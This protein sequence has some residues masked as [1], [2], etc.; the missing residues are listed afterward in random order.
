LFTWFSAGGKNKIKGKAIEVY[1]LTKRFAGHRALSGIDF[2]VQRGSIHGFL[3]PNG[4]GKTTAIK[5]ILGLIPATSGRVRVLGEPLRFGRKLNFLQHLNYLPQDPVF[6]EGLT[7][8]EALN[9]V[10]DIY[11]LDRKKSRSRIDRLLNYFQLSDA[12]S[13]RVGAYSRGMQQRLGVA[14]VL[15]SEPELLILDEPVSALDPEGRRRVLEIIL[16]LKGRATV[17][18]SSHILADVERVCDHV[19]IIEKGKKLLDADTNE[20]LNRYSM[21]Q[22]LIT[23][24]PGQEK[25]AASLIKENSSVREVVPQL[26]KL[27]VVSEPG[28][29]VAMSEELLPMLIRRGVT[30]TE[31]MQNRTNLEGAFFRLLEENQQ[32]E[33]IR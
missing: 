31:F 8:R 30:V 13:R 20:L 1:D 32:T 18:F 2:S 15:L 19:T 26:G 21:E 17:F 23:V 33:A 7:G 5:I 6:P 11:R 24:K 4:A 16:K 29:S 10:A 3:G 25:T 9:L 27:L 28:R 22:Y 14:A 12:A